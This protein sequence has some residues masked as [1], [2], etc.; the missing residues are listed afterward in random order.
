MH[1]PFRAKL[2][3]NSS[4]I[5]SSTAIRPKYDFFESFQ[6]P[7]NKKNLKIVYEVFHASLDDKPAY[8]AL[9]HVGDLPAPSTQ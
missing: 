3:D 4:G 1:S 8:K 9:I 6:E 2:T 7:P 5:G